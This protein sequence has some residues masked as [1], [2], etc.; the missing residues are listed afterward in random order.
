MKLGKKK[1]TLTQR[2]AAFRVAVICPKKK[3][4]R[5][6]VRRKKNNRP[7][8][9]GRCEASADVAVSQ[10]ESTDRPQLWRF[11]FYFERGGGAQKTGKKRRH[12]H[13]D[14]RIHT[15][16]HTHPKH[17]R[18]EKNK[19]HSSDAEAA[20]R[21]STTD[22]V[23]RLGDAARGR[24]R[25]GP[26]SVSTT[27]NSTTGPSGHLMTPDRPPDLFHHLLH[28]LLHLLRPLLLR[29]LKRASN[30]RTSVKRKKKKKRVAKLGFDWIS[31]RSA[32]HERVTPWRNRN[33][34]VWCGLW[35][36]RKKNSTRS[37]VSHEKSFLKSFTWS[38]NSADA[39]YM[40][41]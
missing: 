34:S 38:T 26:A 15:H 41:K 17:V 31:T 20:H 9:Q 14:T 3:S 19:T 8:D 25:R 24:R 23:W 33:D 36:E 21:R 4:N 7:I 39:I 27:A 28:L 6:V 1:K 12:T 29:Y 10:S 32:R 13:T 11:F 2:F 30:G 35:D 37:I 40:D 22:V 18:G 16:T 5:N